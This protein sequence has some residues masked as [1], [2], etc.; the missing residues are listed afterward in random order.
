[1]N[2]QIQYGS[3]RLLTSVATPS[4]RRRARVADPVR[5]RTEPTTS[6]SVV[7]LFGVSLLLALV[8]PL[9]AVVVLFFPDQHR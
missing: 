2:G 4:R 7:L 6:R 8:C 9:L 1:M 3:A 5:F